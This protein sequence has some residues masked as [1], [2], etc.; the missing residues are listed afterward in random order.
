MSPERERALLDRIDAELEASLEVSPSA[1]F[2]PA[3]RRRM[4]ESP[5]PRAAAARWWLAPVLATLAA[6]LV[7]AHLLEN[8]SRRTGPPVSPPA[9][10]VPREQAVERPPHEAPASA[11]PTPA[12]VAEAAPKPD[13]MPPASPVVRS[14]PRVIVP[15]EDEEAV[16]RLA[17]RLRGHAARAEVL[18]PTAEGPFD[19]NLGPAE[20]GREV[21]SLDQ[22]VVPGTQPGPG[23]PLSFD[24]TFEQTGRET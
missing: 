10:V 7:G 14:V 5:A 8:T 6:I 15:P 22:G 23:E 9:G 13:P 3:V 2:L 18:V 20:A 12:R 11:A 16:R 4:A 1:T 19:F 21:V 24:S 17:R